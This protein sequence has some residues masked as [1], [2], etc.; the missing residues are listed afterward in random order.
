MGGVFWIDSQLLPDIQ[1]A[2][3]DPQLPPPRERFIDLRRTAGVRVWAG[4]AKD[5]T[6]VV[7]QFH[8]A[9]TDGIGAIQFIGDLLA[10]YGLL[11]CENPRLAP[12]LSPLQHNGLIHRGQP[13]EPEHR[14]RRLL[15]RLAMW[16]WKL[17]RVIPTDLAARQVVSE[18]P[19]PRIK[20]APPASD[21][22]SLFVT[23]ILS[24]EQVL[25]IKA[26]A[27]SRGCMSN[28]LYTLAMFHALE[29]WNRSCGRTTDHEAYRVGLPVTL[30]TPRHDDSPAANILSYMFL[31][32]KGSELSDHQQ[33]LRHIHETSHSVLISS[34]SGL[35]C[36]SMGV[37]KRIPGMLRLASC[38][39]VRFCTTILANVGDVRR[40]FR[41]RFS[42]DK[43][44]CV[45]GNI[46][47]E[48][49]LGAAPIRPGTWLGLS[50]GIYAK[51]LFINLNCAPLRFSSE[52][53]NRL[54][55]L[56]VSSLLDLVQTTSQAG[57]SH[58][59]E[60]APEPNNS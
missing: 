55:D 16:T 19:C 52:D 5:F 45:A 1:W 38:S 4:V 36:W 42:L 18:A 7:F 31:T 27:D 8:H 3:G 43:G 30:R 24:P 51:K 14:P 39:P 17:A 15:H 2:E 20:D 44:R 6:R 28:D 11:T 57:S 26:A 35:V 22:A 46:I 56:F 13:W 34:D 58:A 40:H 49:L 32:H 23:R 59:G 60:R 47:L 54:A 29:K 21:A 50:L 10:C 33:M 25:S 53:S 48:Y 12:E 41:S 37:M 9:A